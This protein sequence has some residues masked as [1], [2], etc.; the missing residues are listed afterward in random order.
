MSHQREPAKAISSRLLNMKFM[1]RSSTASSPSSTPNS[2][3][4]KPSKRQKL[5]NGSPST[6]ASERSN[7]TAVIAN[8]EDQKLAGIL[9]KQAEAAGDTHWTLHRNGVSPSSPGSGLNVVSMGYGV[10]DTPQRVADTAAGQ[11]ESD[12]DDEV[13][14]LQRS[15]SSGRLSFGKFNK[16][17]EVR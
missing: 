6:P 17:I 2:A 9:L 5:A 16:V 3:Q 15:K 11:D 1:Q 7:Q 8:S 4:A 13:P 14:H 12:V 10:I